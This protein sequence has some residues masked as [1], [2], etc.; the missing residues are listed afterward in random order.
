VHREISRLNSTRM[1]RGG[2]VLRDEL[3]GKSWE[4]QT[5]IG[6]HVVVRF[7]RKADDGR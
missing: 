3:N 6:R 4:Y 1:F 7:T 2:K 5:E